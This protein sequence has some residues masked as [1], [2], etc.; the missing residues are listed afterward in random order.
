VT[1]GGRYWLTSQ[2]VKERGVPPRF[3]PHDDS[4]RDR[5]PPVYSIV[6]T[7]ETDSYPVDYFEFWYRNK[8]EFGMDVLYPVLHKGRFNAIC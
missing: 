2:N 3:R 7:L 1:S 8:A 5:I 6:A 4:R